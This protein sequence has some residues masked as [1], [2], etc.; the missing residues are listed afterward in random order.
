MGILCGERGSTLPFSFSVSIPISK[1]TINSIALR[2]TKI[3]Y[4]FGLSECNRVK[5]KNVLPEEKILLSVYPEL[6]GL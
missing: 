3:A 1:Y 5:E 6:V 2:K 4:N